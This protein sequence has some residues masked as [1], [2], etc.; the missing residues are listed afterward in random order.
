M[1]DP[2]TFARLQRHRATPAEDVLWQALRGRRLSGLKFRRQ[3]PLLGYVVDFLCDACGLIVE[4]DGR[5]HGWHAEYDARRTAEIE[6]AGYVVLRFANE[7]VTNDLDA[8]LRAIQA[9][10]LPTPIGRGVGGEG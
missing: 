5:Q 10:A 2:I 1:S 4:L 6:A 7:R 9:G 8:V 3:V